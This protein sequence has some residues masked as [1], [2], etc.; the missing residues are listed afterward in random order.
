MSFQLH[1]KA[2]AKRT[3]ESDQC[4]NSKWQWHHTWQVEISLE[5]WNSAKTTPT[6]VRVATACLEPDTPGEGCYHPW[7]SVEQWKKISQGNN[8][9]KHVQ[10]VQTA[11]PAKHRVHL[12]GM[13]FATSV[14]CSKFLV[15]ILP[16][17]RT[18]GSPSQSSTWDGFATWQQPLLMCLYTSRSPTE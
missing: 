4:T 3:D 6:S 17:F 5:A 13:K 8:L 14:T 15:A 12:Y 9:P 1:T 2:H 11:T 18:T 7:T 16:H 10:E